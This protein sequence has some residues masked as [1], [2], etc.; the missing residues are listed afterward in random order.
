[1]N[2]LKFFIMK[3]GYY[4][5]IESLPPGTIVSFPPCMHAPYYHII[6]PTGLD[7]GGVMT[8]LHL[9]C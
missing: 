6:P 8:L 1:M 7:M 9:H 3:Q 4:S 2:E 5:T